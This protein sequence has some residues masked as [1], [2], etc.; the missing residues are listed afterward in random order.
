MLLKALKNS[1]HQIGVGKR[2][3]YKRHKFKMA[4]FH[5]SLFGN[6]VSIFEIVNCPYNIGLHYYIDAF[7]LGVRDCSFDS[8]HT[9][10]VC[11]LGLKIY[12]S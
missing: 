11:H 5:A 7:T 8:T 6:E 10:L 4:S 12:L 1:T 9:M 3:R 2:K